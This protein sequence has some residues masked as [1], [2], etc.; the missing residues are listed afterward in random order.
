MLPTVDHPRLKR[1]AVEARA[2]QLEG[3]AEALEC[4]TL[5]VYPTAAGKTAVSAMVVAEVISD[6][7]RVVMLAPTVGLVEQH[8]S[9]L[10]N[11]LTGEVSVSTLT[12][13]TAREKRKPLWN[14]SMVIIATPQVFHNDVLSGLIDPSTIE[15]LIVDEAHH[16][17]GSHAMGKSCDEFI[18]RGGEKILAMTASPGYSKSH[19][20]A[21]CRR[22][23]IDRIHTR[24]S[25]DSGLKRYLSDLELI[26]VRVEVPEELVELASPLKQWQEG[27]IDTERRLGRY[28]HEGK[29]TY[30][31]LCYRK[32][33]G[34]HF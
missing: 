24:S 2:Y 30:S 20:E 4:S 3:V 17:V 34:R 26:E 11:W 12:G 15:I 13:A 9:T 28:V 32:G 31:G 18:I 19:V 5:L 7:G 29:V 1:S 22:L 8:K 21:L 33:E 23:G 14:S 10:T 27:L 6:G 16:S 25:T